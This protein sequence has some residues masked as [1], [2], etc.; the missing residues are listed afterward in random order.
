VKD[1]LLPRV[2]AARARA[3]LK[4]DY[5]SFRRRYG[6]ILR[7]APNPRRGIA[8]LASLSYSTYQ[9]K[10]EGMFAKAFQ[11]QGLEPVVATLPDAGLARRYLE[12]FGVRR[13]V[14]LE[15]YLDPE[16]ERAAQREAATLLERVRNPADLRELRFHGADVGREALSTVSRYLHAGGVRLDDPRARKLLAELLPAA[17]RTALAAE[18]LL[19]DLKPELVL[20]NE[21][22]YA[23][24]GPLCDVALNRGLNVIQFVA[25]FEDDTMVFKRYT[26]ETKGIHPRS[27]SDES[28]S[29][30]A[31][32][33]WTGRHERELEQDFARRYDKSATYFARWNQGWTERHSRD[34][35]VGRLGLD[36]SRR[37]AVVFSHVLWDANMFYGRDL[38]ADQEEWFVETVRAACHNEHVNW[39]VKLHPAN[40]WKRRRDDVTAELDEEVAIRKRVGRLPPHV[41][42]LSPDTPIATWSLFDVTDWGL[43]IRGSVGFELPCFGKPVLTA[44]TG[45]YSG[46]GFTVDSE[47]ADAYLARVSAI[48]DVPPPRDEQVTLARKHA[49]SLF[50]LRQA[51]FVSFRSVYVPLE[52]IGH[53]SE[54]TIELRVRSADELLR[55]DD[56]RRL[57]AWAVGS[58]A[59]DYLEPIPA[60]EAAYDLTASA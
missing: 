14:T 43:T 7:P 18:A 9:V 12:L 54:A 25:G 34:E 59:L 39:I 24:Q 53:P 55:S 38:F 32:M 19:D 57:G 44:G 58:R 5:R 6:E 46:R 13:F 40:V 37:T 31:A 22:N 30:V 26:A 4:R 15:D 8:L 1:R 60:A 27:L 41:H 21:R 16:R 28:W 10:L 49:Y 45:F 52:R 2:R 35:I 33:Q 50:R 3:V 51:R 48:Q 23:D 11:L 36:P 56:L 42:L 20:F 17:I 29:Q 47:T